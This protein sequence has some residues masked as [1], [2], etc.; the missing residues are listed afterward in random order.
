MG[1]LELVKYDELE[2]DRC[3]RRTK[4]EGTCR[5][6]PSKYAERAAVGQTPPEVDECSI[7]A[8]PSRSGLYAPPILHDPK[9]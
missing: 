1:A 8:I 9:I 3:S 4:R 6:P 5:R 7:F 2:E